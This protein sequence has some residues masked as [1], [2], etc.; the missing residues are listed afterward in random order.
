VADL[1]DSHLV[2]IK[3]QQINSDIFIDTQTG[4]RIEACESSD[5]EH[6][7]TDP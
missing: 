7:D 3:Q 2:E 4:L 1:V 6:M 5:E